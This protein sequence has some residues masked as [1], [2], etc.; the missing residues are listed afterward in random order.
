M[1]TD[2]DAYGR[3]PIMNAVAYLKFFNSLPEHFRREALVAAWESQAMIHLLETINELPPDQHAKAYGEV[4]AE[5]NSS[6]RHM[7]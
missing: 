7:R 1:S 3:G 5:M 6:S 4:A 2:N